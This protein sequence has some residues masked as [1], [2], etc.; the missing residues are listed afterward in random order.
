MIAHNPDTGHLT[1]E[2]GPIAEIATTITTG[3]PVE[4]LAAYLRAV[5]AALTPG[6][7][8]TIT[9]A[10]AGG[11]TLTATGPARGKHATR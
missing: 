6:A 8:I 3:A 4:H 1:R 9:T 2:G 5:E 7:T 10:G 11:C